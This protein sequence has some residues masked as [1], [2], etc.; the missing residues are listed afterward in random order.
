MAGR[1]RRGMTLIETVASVVMLSLIILAITKVSQIKMS[2][3]ASVEAQYSVL[4][5]DAFLADIYNEFHNASECKVNVTD[6]GCL[7]L[8][9]INGETD[10]LNVYMFNPS[11]ETCYINGIPQFKAKSFDVLLVS[12]CLYVSLKLPNEK[13]LEMTI[14]R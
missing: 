7:V 10:K 13:L 3:Q 2:D 1:R 6:S 8:E 12:N 4:S 11:E 5:A 9:C 14:Y